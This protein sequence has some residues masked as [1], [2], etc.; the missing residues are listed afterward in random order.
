MSQPGRSLAFEA[1]EW[2]AVTGFVG[3]KA[4][5]SVADTLLNLGGFDSWD[6]GSGFGIR[7]LKFEIW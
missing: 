5:V 4:K 2:F 3:A 7:N 1:G 6:I